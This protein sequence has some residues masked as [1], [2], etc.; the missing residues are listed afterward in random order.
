MSTNTWNNIPLSTYTSFFMSAWIILVK[1]PKF[2]RQSADS[3]RQL[4]TCNK[5]RDRSIQ[6]ITLRAPAKSITNVLRLRLTKTK[7]RKPSRN[8]QQLHLRTVDVPLGMYTDADGFRTINQDHNRRRFLE[9]S[10][11]HSRILSLKHRAMMMHYFLQMYMTSWSYRGRIFSAFKTSSA[12]MN[13]SYF[14]VNC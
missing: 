6:Y 12:R 5:R 7:A 14:Y 4:Q 1:I 11:G 13:V 9:Q 3:V 10:A 8:R 2:K